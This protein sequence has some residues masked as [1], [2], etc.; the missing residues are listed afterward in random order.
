MILVW[1]K[2]YL[3]DRFQYVEIENE[4]SIQCPISYG[5]PQG[6]ILGPLLYLIY[7][8]DIDKSTMGNIL[9]FADDTSLFISDTDPSHLIRTSNIE[10]LVLCQQPIIKSNNNKIHNYQNT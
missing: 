5:V 1:L 8:Y 4:K 7:V 3:S 10:I 9:S 6:S 2:K